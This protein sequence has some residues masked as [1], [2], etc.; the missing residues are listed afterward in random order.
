VEMAWFRKKEEEDES[1]PELPEIDSVMPAQQKKE[2]NYLPSFPSSSGK[3]TEEITK[4]SLDMQQFKPAIS[5]PKMEPE[6][7]RSVEMHR[8]FSDTP[9]SSPGKQI[10][11]SPIPSA[12]LKK[13]E[14][15]FVRID[16]FESALEGIKDIKKKIDEMESLLTSLRQVNAKEDLELSAWEKE[17]NSIKSRI[18]SIDA[19]LFGKLG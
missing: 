1:L 14:P 13:N 17:I 18:D 2:K 11:K 8:K 10:A 16:K 12:V 6:I 9:R 5:L 19:N 4:E 3:M 15:I 7:K